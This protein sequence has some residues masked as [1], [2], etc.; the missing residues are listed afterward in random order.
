MVVIKFNSG[1]GDIV[2]DVGP[3]KSNRKPHLSI[4]IGEVPPEEQSATLQKFVC[5]SLNYKRNE[6]LISIGL[7]GCF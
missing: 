7:P 4:E 2:L 1:N 6:E 5:F 3:I